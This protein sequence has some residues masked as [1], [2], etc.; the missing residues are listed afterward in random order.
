MIIKEFH[1]DSYGHVNNA[2]YLDLLEEA[3]WEFITQ[4]G[5]GYDRV[6]ATQIGPVVLEVHLFFKKEIGLRQSILIE[7]QVISYAGK[8]GDMRQRILNESGELCC[9]AT[10]KFGLFDLSARK[11]LMPNKD[12]L[13]AV[14]L[15][16]ESLK[17]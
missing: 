14:G 2:R 15:Q 9:E 10:L 5:Y 4:N 16:S 8:V 11:L 6:H 7:S 1:L 12:W 13:W 17:E 3:R